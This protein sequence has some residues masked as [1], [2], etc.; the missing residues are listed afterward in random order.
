[1]E[2][3]EVKTAELT[4]PALDWAVAQVESKSFSHID[5]NGILYVAGQGGCDVWSPSTDW[6]QGGPLIAKRKVSI[7]YHNGPDCTPMACLSGTHPA[8]ECG[9]TVLIAA[10]RA[11]VAAK[12]GGAVQVPAAL[13]GGGA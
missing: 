9:E 2:M 4:G 3:I 13:I 1:M 10:C 11:I 12:L 6:S 5:D 8:F 7:A